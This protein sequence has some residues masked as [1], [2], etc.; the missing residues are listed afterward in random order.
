MKLTELV[1]GITELTA[2]TEKSRA[3]VV[4]AVVVLNEK[5]GALEVNVTELLNGELSPD[6]IAS[7]DALKASVQAID[8]LNTDATP[9][10]P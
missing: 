7:F 9:P 5:I 1:T 4:A 2:Q 3:E 6:V 8:D 10:T